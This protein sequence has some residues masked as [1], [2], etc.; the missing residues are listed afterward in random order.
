MKA[1]DR[2]RFRNAGAAAA[3]LALLS[4][5]AP[6]AACS[7]FPA[8]LA[9]A[10][11]STALD[12]DPNGAGALDSF[13]SSYVSGR[14][15]SPVRIVGLFDTAGDAAANMTLALGRARRAQVYL[16]ARGIPFALMRIVLFGE[17]RQPSDA[18]ARTAVRVIEE[19]PRPRPE[20]SRGQ[21]APL[22]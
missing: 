15:V 16:A 21:P 12:V 13:A 1:F 14:S 8:E 17:E 22:C 3:V 4:P 9:F 6:A 10:T 7:A 20:V 19:Q 5:S 18:P 2:R 11:D